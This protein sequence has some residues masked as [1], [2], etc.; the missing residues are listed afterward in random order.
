MYVCISVF[1][2]QELKEDQLAEQRAMEQAHKEAEELLKKEQ[3]RLEEEER[4]LKEEQERLEREEA[5]KEARVKKLK[6]VGHNTE[7]TFSQMITCEKLQQSQRDITCFKPA[8]NI[9]GRRTENCY[10]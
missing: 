3:E 10:S 7:E 1:T 2:E 6:E 5:E 8:V 9:C 4:K